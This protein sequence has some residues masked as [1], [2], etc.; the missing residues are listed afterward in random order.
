MKESPLLLLFGLLTAVKGVLPRWPAI[1]LFL[2]P[3]MDFIAYGSYAAQPLSSVPLSGLAA[4]SGR[5][6]M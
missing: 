1:I 6:K 3:I 2:V 5:D 4:P